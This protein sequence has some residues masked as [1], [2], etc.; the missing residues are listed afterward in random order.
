MRLFVIAFAGGIWW[1]QQQAGLPVAATLGGVCLA[2][3]IMLGAAW[4]GRES[5]LMKPL[6]SRAVEQTTLSSPLRMMLG[7]LF[8]RALLVSGAACLGFL[9]AAGFA[10][11]RMAEELPGSLEG[12]D[13]QITG[14]VSGLPQ[15]LERGLRF[16]FDVEQALPGVPPHISL[17]WYRGRDEAEDESLRVPVRAGERWRFTVRLKRP[18]GNMNPHGFDYEAWL[19]ERGIRATGYVRPKAQAERLDARVWRPGYAVE[20]LREAIRDRFR[21]ALPEAPYAGILIALAIG[22]QQAIA[23]DLWQ[24]FGRTGITHLMSISGLHVTM[25]A[26]LAYAL[27]NWLWRR[28]PRLPLRLPAQHA[29]ALGGLLAA[30]AYCLL[31]GFAVPA[32][33]TL[34]MLGVVAV[35]HLSA[36]EVSASRVLALALLLVLLLDPW[37]VLA[38]GFWLSFGAVGLLFFIGGG[39]LGP[40]HWLV[41]W[42]RAQWAV[43]LGML[44]ALLALFQ[45]FSL[46]SPLANALAIPLVSFLITPLAIA[47]C[48][49]LLDPL[50][51]LA[52]W[53]TAG[54]MLAVDWMAALPLAVW[55]QSA[56]PGWAVVLALAGGA[57][58]LLPRGFPSRWLGLLAFLPL[59]TIEAPRPAAGNAAITVLDVGQGLAIHVQTASH[60]LL[61]D[62]GPAFSSDADSGNRIIAPYLRAMGVRRLDTLV[63]SHADKDHEGGAASV[64]AALPAAMLKTSLPFEHPLSAQPVRHELCIDGDGW[65]WDGVRFEMLH[66]TGE[67]VSRKSN[68]LSCVLRV[69]AGGRTVLLTSDIEAVSEQALLTRYDKR[70]AADV[71][72][73]PHHGSRTSST[74]EFIAAVG[75][76][77]VIFPVGYRNRFG[78]PKDDVVARY[79]ASG[80]RLHRSDA[81]GAIRVDL[82]PE[83]IGI[84]HQRAESRRYWHGDGS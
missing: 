10:H 81:H 17:A 59:L 40:A 58:S 22:D 50:L 84:R 34:Y 82:A 26:G 33:R 43:T 9:W 38:A 28:S 12:I 14:V 54:M 11:W 55:Q 44:P 49:P 13:I 77:D 42:S 83:G 19:F 79:V 66:P 5:A 30:F 46:V 56:P 52:H 23:P 76:R 15:E 61:F 25:L 57:W 63:I 41:E 39:R 48:L 24:A 71:M 78:H 4:S 36:R 73:V 72:T 65:E 21:A 32:Q 67:P 27:V 60:D 62:A 51:A 18:H 7:R 31:A 53:I 68:D 74:P 6:R 47:G 69:M 2:A 1:L 45:Q 64:L 3:V 20:M 8:S 37:A 70:L 29:A 16:G 35:A 75:A 80:A